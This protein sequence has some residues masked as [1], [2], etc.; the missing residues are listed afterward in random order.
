MGIIAMLALA[1]G[2]FSCVVH[3]AVVIVQQIKT[4]TIPALDM[5]NSGR[6]PT[7]STK[8]AAA[9][10]IGTRSVHV[11]EIKLLSAT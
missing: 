3:S 2:R 1:A 8:S 7:L 9:V 11:S 10:N 5:R 4:T 6:R